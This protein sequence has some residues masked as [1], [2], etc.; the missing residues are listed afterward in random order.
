MSG[1]LRLF[2]GL[3]LPAD[4][5]SSVWGQ[6]APY[7]EHH[8]GARWLSPQTWHLTLLFLGSVQEDRLSEVM[9]LVE[10]VA[11]M[12]RPFD[13]SI[14]GG[15]GRVR[16]G[17]GVAWLRVADGAGQVSEL[18]GHLDVDCPHDIAAGTPPRRT[19]AA[20]VTVAR[21]AD[22]DLVQDLAA[23]RWGHPEARWQA[24]SM[25]LLRSSLGP[26]GAHY[27][28]LLETSLYAGR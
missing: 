13:L 24:R 15:G 2:I 25:T 18:S 20:H 11:E 16:E 7:R 19:P 8:R 4:V 12:T 17:E 21:A 3:S 9:A 27:E 6:L 10:H 14:A 5:Q 1:A 23:D 26:R 22:R 28:T